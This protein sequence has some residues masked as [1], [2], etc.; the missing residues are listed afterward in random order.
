MSSRV[1]VKRSRDVTFTKCKRKIGL[2]SALFLFVFCHTTKHMTHSRSWDMGCAP[3]CDIFN[4]AG[5]GSSYFHVPLTTVR[6]LLNVLSS[7]T[8]NCTATLG[9]LS[10]TE[11]TLCRAMQQL[12]HGRRS[13][14]GARFTRY[15]TTYNRKFIVRS[16]YDSDLKRANVSFRNIV[17]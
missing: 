6:H 7:I 12:Q 15:L 14:P 5:G 11:M 13:H 2:Y 4:R 8:T 9:M 17:S 1:T 16:T 3:S 10:A